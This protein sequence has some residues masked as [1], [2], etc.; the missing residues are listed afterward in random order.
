MKNVKLQLPDGKEIELE[1]NYS[2]YES[3]FDDKIPEKECL[4]LINE[5]IQN[6][7]ISLIKEICREIVIGGEN[8][9]FLKDKTSRHDDLKYFYQYFSDK[10]QNIRLNQ[11]SA[12]IGGLILTSLSSSK[13]CILDLKSYQEKGKNILINF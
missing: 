8:L 9:L 11:Y 3:L 6:N 2:V 4:S 7:H 10:E 5:S 1:Q 12:F 13:N